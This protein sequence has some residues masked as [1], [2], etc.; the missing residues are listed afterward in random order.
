MYLV[1]YLKCND[2]IVLPNFKAV[3]QTQ[4]ESHIL[5][6]KKSDVCIR[7]L[8][9]N[10]VTQSILHLHYSNSLRIY[11]AHYK[12]VRVGATSEARALPLFRAN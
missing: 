3:G 4:V 7:S 1:P 9:V 12:D 5:K 6:V 10:T 8:F 2:R 11:M